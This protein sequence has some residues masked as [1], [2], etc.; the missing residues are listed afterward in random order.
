MKA[1]W[2]EDQWIQ[3]HQSKPEGDNIPVEIVDSNKQETVA[4]KSKPQVGENLFRT[5]RRR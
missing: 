5:L 1:V 2:S 4:R 3:E